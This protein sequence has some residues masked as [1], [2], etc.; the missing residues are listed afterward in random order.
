MQA[1]TISIE[2][3]MQAPDLSTF[4]FN[5]ETTAT[6]LAYNVFKIWN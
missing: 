3:E 5:F 2:L 1:L 4:Y 6:P